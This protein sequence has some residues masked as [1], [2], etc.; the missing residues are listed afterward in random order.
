MAFPDLLKQD[1]ALAPYT[2]IGL[3][4]RADW[5]AEIND[6]AHLHEG[7]AWAAREKIPALVLGGGSNLILPDEGVRGLVLRLA[8]SG[9][10]IEADDQQTADQDAGDRLDGGGGVL[11]TAEAGTNWDEFVQATVEAGLSGVECLSGIPGTVGATPIQNVGAYG[12]EV[13][14]TIERVVCL[15]RATFEHRAFTNEQCE[16]AY[17]QSRFKSR[18]R[19]RFIVLSVSYRLRRH[20]IA[21]LRYGEL[22]QRLEARFGAA[23][24]G[25]G[26]TSGHSGVA[27]TTLALP[28]GVPG[29][30][31]IRET[32][33]ELRRGKSMVLD[34]QDP[35]S[36]SA[37]SFFLNPVL[38]SEDVE[39]VAR[40]ALQRGADQPPPQY[41]APSGIKL[42]AAWLI[43][44]AGFQ[45]GFR[46]PGAAIS[47]N[48]CLALINPGEGTRLNLLELAE[49][50]QA[51]VLR[52]FGVRLEIEPEIYGTRE[53]MQ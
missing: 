25:G 43:E 42:S 36:R 21:E 35:N 14:Q 27:G 19:N 15:D 37:G 26:Q 48:H 46:R 50:I 22:R 3:G 40:I 31:A 32:V 28:A 49:E 12:Q 5:F 16:F 11:A 6:V 41:P 20:A 24:A 45:K 7:L 13:S 23:D 51:G 30:Q 17:R 8:F 38:D 47:A 1:E 33:L 53:T 9:I 34:P 29:L 10:R 18:D 2:T 44:R 4:G 39:R 52:V